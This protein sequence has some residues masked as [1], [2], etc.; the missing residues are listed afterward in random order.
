MPRCRY[1][2][3]DYWPPRS[4]I[5]PYLPGVE[6]PCI[7]FF[8]F[9]VWAFTLHYAFRTVVMPSNIYKWLEPK[10]WGARDPIYCSVVFIGLNSGCKERRESLTFSVIQSQKRKEE[11]KIEIVIYFFIHLLFPPGLRNLCREL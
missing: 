3:S 1:S 10:A 2:V 6:L 8:F 5:L 4:S 9:P 7:F 11:V